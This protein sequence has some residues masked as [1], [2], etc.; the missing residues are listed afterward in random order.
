MAPNRF[1][2]VSIL[3]MLLVSACVPLAETAS[4]EFPQPTEPNQVELPTPLPT[5]PLYE[6]GTLVDYTAQTGDTLPGLAARFNTTVAEIRVANPIIPPDA[7]TMPPGF[8]MRIPIYYK[9]LWGSPFQILPDSLYVN[10]PAQ[11]GFTAVE[12]LADTG[13][14]LNTYTGFAG[15]RNRTG[16]QIVDYVSTVYSISPRLLLALLEYQT[17]SVL[18]ASEPDSTG[19][20]TLGYADAYHRGLYLQLV[21]AANTLNDAYYGWRAGKLD[22]VNFSDRRLMHPDP[23]QNA[24]SV[25]LQAYYAQVMPTTTDYDRAVSANGF[26]NTYTQ[27]FGDPWLDVQPHIPGSLTQP[28]MSLPFEP[29]KTWSYTGGPHTAWGSGNPWAAIDFAPPAVVGG[30]NPT[31]EWA[32]AVADGVIA[33]TDLATAMLDLDG[34]GDERTGWVVFYLH[35]ASNDKVAAGTVVQRGDKLGHPSCEGGVS[36]GTHVHIARKYNG[37][38]I[39][40]DGALPFN[41][42]GWVAG[43]GAQAYLGTLTRAGRRVEACVCSNRESQITAERSQ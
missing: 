42:D 16:S 38:W 34:D 5:R 6:P 7:T 20:Y 12:Y 30:C 9:A 8:P 31:Q 21:W 14:W 1:F 24:A 33:R 39:L 19:G 36:T 41:L 17:Q 3:F 22:Q 27:L 13:S 10:G 11:V 15:E 35:L 29:G 2:R 37:E 40:A 4:P 25:A 32:T 23:W 18:S 28:D 43:D 26:L